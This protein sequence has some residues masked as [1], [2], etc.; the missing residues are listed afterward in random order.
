MRERRGEIK[1]GFGGRTS[2]RREGKILMLIDRFVNIIAATVGFAGAI[3]LVRGVL[4]ISPDLIGKLSQTSFDYSLPQL[5]NLSVQ[6]ADVVSGG[7]LIL[8][9]FTLQIVV[10]VTVRRPV[11]ILGGHW[12][13]VVIAL[14]LAIFVVAIFFGLNGSLRSHFE[15]GGKRYLVKWYLNR[16][17]ANNPIRRIYFADVERNADSLLEFRKNDGESDRAFLG[18]LAENMNIPLPDNLQMEGE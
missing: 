14:E 7:C 6:K 5:R 15:D 9:A 11:A 1:E 12:L 10:L 16:A 18:R 17:L 4:A 2:D 13:A 3:L 8:L